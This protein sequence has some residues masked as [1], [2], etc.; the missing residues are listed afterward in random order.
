[1]LMGK[2]FAPRSPSP[3]IREPPKE[4]RSRSAI[5]AVRLT[6]RDDGDATVVGVG[7]RGEH[8]SDTTLVFDRDV[9]TLWP[10]PNVGIIDTRVADLAGDR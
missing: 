1:M 3:R 2:P 10:A 7:P 8:V 5:D 9:Q 4:V 6:V